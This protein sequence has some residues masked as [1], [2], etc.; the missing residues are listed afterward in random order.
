MSCLVRKYFSLITSIKS[1]FLI[2]F[3]CTVLYPGLSIDGQEPA[4]PAEIKSVLLLNSYHKGFLWTDEITRGVED[5]FKGEKI[6]LH[7]EYM[8]AKRQYNDEY[9]GLLKDILKVKHE[10]QHYDLVITS[11]NV[12]FDFVKN[13]REQVFGDIPFIFCGVNNL[14]EKDIEGLENATGV[15]ETADLESNFHLIHKIHPDARRIITIADNTVSGRRIQDEVLRLREENEFRSLGIELV[16]DVTVDELAAKLDRL[17]D[18]D[19]VFLTLFFRDNSEQFLTYDT[20]AKFVS[21]NTRVPVYAAWK[22]NLGHGIVGGCLTSGYD[23]GIIAAKKGVVA[24]QDVPVESIPIEWKSKSRYG[25]DYEKLQQ[26]GIKLEDLPL[27][28]EILH[29]PNSFYD[30]HRELIWKTVLLFVCMFIAILGLLYGFARAKKS[31]SKFRKL[32]DRAPIAL[33]KCNSLTNKVLSANPKGVELMGYR[34]EKELISSMKMTDLYVDIVDR[35]QILDELKQTGLVLSCEFHAKKRDG[36]RFWVQFSAQIVS[37]NKPEIVEF[38]LIDES[39]RKRAE[40][41]LAENQAKM[42]EVQRYAK[43]GSWHY[44]FGEKFTFW[45]D[46]LQEILGI[47]LPSIESFMM[48]V[49]PDDREPARKSHADATKFSKPIETIFRYNHPDGEMRYLKSWANVHHSKYGNPE[50]M[51][52]ITQDITPQI[53]NQ[54]HLERLNMLLDSIRGINQLIVKEVN[55]D[56]L[57]DKATRL[58]VQGKGFSYAGAVLLEE[59][60]VTVT[61]ENP[62]GKLSSKV[63]GDVELYPPHLSAM[64]S[65]EVSELSNFRYPSANMLDARFVDWADLEVVTCPLEYQGKV[66]GFLSSVYEQGGLEEEGNDLIEEVCN[67][68]AFA[69]SNIELEQHKVQVLHELLEAKEKAESASKAKDDFLAIMSHELR[70]PLNPILGYAQ[71]MQ[72]DH[73]DEPEKSYLEDIISS[74]SDQLKLI[75]G[76]LEFIEL[77]NGSKAINYGLCDVQAL[78][79]TVILQ[80]KSECESLSFKIGSIDGFDEFPVGLLARTDELILHK[81]L[82]R[83]LDNAC[84]YTNEGTITTALGFRK[85]KPGEI[86]VRFSVRDTGIG[87]RKEVMMNLFDPFTQGDGSISRNFQGIGIGLAVSQKLVTLLGGSISVQSDG[88]TGSHFWIDVPMKTESLDL[89][90]SILK[91]NG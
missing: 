39:E 82:N 26:H 46:E 24:L 60:R 34:S 50:K 86:K 59:D 55:V 22:F 5:V 74:A 85:G 72:D 90:G 15:S 11:D 29:L 3:S 20:A 91:D 66:Y 78:F 41:A 49:H 83:I 27:M 35:K 71:L 47:E 9:L 73:T 56:L 33:F 69:I 12:A 18:G 17:T 4:A 79:D 45:S 31:E 48:R 84:K 89:S 7:V 23:Q 21:S 80:A 40:L 58:L 70:T 1:N 37:Y 75:D 25:F 2:L 51:V 64:I 8:D 87:I 88:K 65:G 16:C 43:I 42:Q 19:I 36:E 57:M 68:L 14:N 52:G 10:K 77:G 30:N 13:W 61:A 38:F 76:I 53:L 6:Q 54:K 28:S 63:E 44:Q 81:V 62:Q 67:D 32:H